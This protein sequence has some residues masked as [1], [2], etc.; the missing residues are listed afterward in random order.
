MTETR[1]KR[2]ETASFTHSPLHAHW[3]PG[4]GLV[5]P[6]IW[7]QFFSFQ[8]TDHNPF[9][10]YNFLRFTPL[11]RKNCVFMNEIEYNC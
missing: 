11:D 3:L 7:S 8:I 9:F 6:E 4:P 10:P 2:S 5:G 1:P